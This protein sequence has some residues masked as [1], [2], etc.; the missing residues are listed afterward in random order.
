[1]N[2]LIV[3]PLKTEAQKSKKKNQ[4]YETSHVSTQLILA[5]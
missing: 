1:M 4:T 2:G 3:S 5:V